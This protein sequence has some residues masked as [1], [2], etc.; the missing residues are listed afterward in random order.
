MAARAQA[1][2][3]VIVE[4][5]VVCKADVCSMWNVLTDTERLNRAVGMDKV[6]L[7]PLSNG[8]AARYL[9]TTR[10]GG[11]LVQYEERPYEWVYLKSFKVLRKMRSGPVESLEMSYVLDEAT[12]GGTD[13]HLKL[14]MVPRLRILT[15]FIKLRAAQTL[16]RFEREVERLDVVLE[17]RG[18]PRA[19]SPLGALH[20]GMLQRAADK[21]HEVADKD[22]TDR[23]VTYVSEAGD[24]EVSRIRPFALADEW[25]V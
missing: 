20:T 2:R 1:D 6:E 19:A 7:A 8:T 16:K 3:G 4:R 14:T 9:A 25:G 11:F 24:V 21:L 13:V 18:P 23:L 15:P 17:T 12:R 5:S 22:L 10:L